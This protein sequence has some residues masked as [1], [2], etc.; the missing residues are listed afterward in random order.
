M[1]KDDQCA[2]CHFS[3]LPAPKGDVAI[4]RVSQSFDFARIYLKI[5]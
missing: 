4:W 1:E 5:M 3:N 2:Y